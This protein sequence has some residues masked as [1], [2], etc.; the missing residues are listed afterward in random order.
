MAWPL[1]GSMRNSCKL[2]QLFEVSQKGDFLNEVGT[3][4][5]HQNVQYKQESRSNTAGPNGTD[6][7]KSKFTIQVSPRLSIC[8][9][10]RCAEWTLY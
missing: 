9:H 6:V 2:L 4:A 3:D 1:F 5:K 8:E 10:V 7:P